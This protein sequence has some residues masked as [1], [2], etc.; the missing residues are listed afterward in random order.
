MS[1]FCFIIIVN[2]LDCWAYSCDCW[3]VYV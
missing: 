2:L 3:S 1:F